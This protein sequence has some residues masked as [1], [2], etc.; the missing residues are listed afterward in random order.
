MRARS[1]PFDLE[2]RGLL[3]RCSIAREPSLS[4]DRFR[5]EYR[6]RKPVIFTP[7]WTTPSKGA[8]TGDEMSEDDRRCAR[9]AEPQVFK[10]KYATMPLPLIDTAGVA[11]RGFRLTTVERFFEWTDKV[12][13]G[14]KGRFHRNIE[15]RREGK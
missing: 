2:A 13:G 12:R 8:T 6:D 9:A 5:S 1:V 4:L 10:E 14:R 15:R 11:R 7:A 3:S